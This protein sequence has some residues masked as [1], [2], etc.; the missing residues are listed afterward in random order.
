MTNGFQSLW[1]NARAAGM[2]AVEA[3]DVQPM[4]VVGEKRYFVADG[5][6][7]FAWVNVKPGTSKFAKWLKASGHARTDS[8]YGGVTVWVSQFNQSMQKKEA[9]AY[10]MAKVFAEAGF[11]AYA[12]SRMD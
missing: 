6:C 10:A 4:V 5:V 1:D 3:L 8:Y 11:D 2:A 12:N 9:Y 7:G